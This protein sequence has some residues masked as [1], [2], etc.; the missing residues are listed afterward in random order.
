MAVAEL[1]K[2]FA[3]SLGIEVRLYSP[4]SSEAARL[5]ALLRSHDVDCVLDVGANRGQYVKKLRSAGYGG[6]VVSFEPLSDVHAR[7]RQAAEK[8]ANWIIAPRL[9]LGS[10]DGD[11]Y[12]NVAENLVS[13]SIKE[14]TPRH[15]AAAGNARYVGR[16]R[17]IMRRLDGV[18]SEY[19]S[20]ARSPFL[21]V[22]TQGAEEEVLAGAEGC[23]ERLAGLQVEMSL[24]ELY[25]GQKLFL[26]LTTELLTRRFVLE[27]LLPG[28]VD[29]N[30]GQLLQ[31]DGIFF[32]DVHNQGA[33]IRS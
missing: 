16:E 21:K 17:V 26:E 24:V 32:R 11:T 18:F 3:R 1:L 20:A 30:T 8:D 15:L 31:V 25:K 33:D 2:A 5:V 10:I 4:R 29:S 22:D 6:V 12:I 14:I 23:L 27:G 9:A 13:S 19:A 7:L 28:L